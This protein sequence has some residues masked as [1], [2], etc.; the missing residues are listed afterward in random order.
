MSTIYA[1]GIRYKS[2]LLFFVFLAGF[3][4]CRNPFATREPEEP[5]NSQTS[6]YQPVSPETVLENFSAAVREKNV[7]NYIRCFG[8]TESVRSRFRFI[9]ESSVSNNYQGLFAVWDITHERNYINHLFGQLPAD[10]VSSLIFT[11][12]TE[13]QYGDSVSTM[14]EYDLYVAHTNPSIE[15][16]VTGRMELTLLKGTDALWYISYWADYKIGDTPVWSILKAEF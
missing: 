6:W 11:D 2:I 10:S 14:K 7:E 12:V 13:F 1:P 9:P 8:S 15:R 5:E 3:I 4:T 16:H